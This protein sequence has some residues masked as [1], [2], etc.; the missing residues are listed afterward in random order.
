MHQKGPSPRL[1][2]LEASSTPLVVAFL[3][4]LPMMQPGVELARS[5]PHLPIC[6]YRNSSRGANYG[7]DA[8]IVQNRK[9]TLLDQASV[10]TLDTWSEW[11]S[12]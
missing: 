10:W 12:I 9:D 7:L 8:G 3:F 6:R 4:L 2:S 5:L 11:I 1:I